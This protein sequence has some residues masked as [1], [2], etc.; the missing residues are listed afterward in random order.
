MDF[1][2]ESLTLTELIQL[3]T[4]LSQILQRRFER[5]LALAFTDVAGSTEHFARYGNEA[6]RAL[7]Q[8]YLDLLDKVLPGAQGRIVDTAGD[9][10]FTCF[11]GAGL[12]CQAM[13]DLQQA[14]NE[15]NFRFSRE[16]QLVVRC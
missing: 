8:R 15:E 13:V 11:P 2:A 9:G 3:Q 14:I 12:A 7:I 6:G 1:D 16:Q 10:A 4:H 5:Q